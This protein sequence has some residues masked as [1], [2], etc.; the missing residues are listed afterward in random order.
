MGPVLY[1]GTR[2]GC[3]GDGRQHRKGRSSRYPT[4]SR[5]DHHGDGG[6]QIVGQQKSEGCSADGQVDQPCRQ[7]VGEALHRG[8]GFLGPAHGLDDAAEGG[9]G[10][11]P[12]GADLD[13]P[14]LVD[15]T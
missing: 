2:P 13:G 4:G 12:F 9:F 1:E 3:A 14:R 5:H 7:P 8:L 10:S 15:G 11:H 6:G